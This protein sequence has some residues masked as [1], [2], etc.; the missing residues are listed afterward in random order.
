[1]GRAGPGRG[2]AD[3]RPATHVPSCGCD[4]SSRCAGRNARRRR[5]VARLPDRAGDTRGMAL[6]ECHQPSRMCWGDLPERS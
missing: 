5:T 2:G 6:L 4:L 3:R 1:M